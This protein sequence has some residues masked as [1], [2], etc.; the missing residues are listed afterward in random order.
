VIDAWQWLVI[1]GSCPC[2]PHAVSGTAE[3]A[4]GL[5]ERVLKV[6]CSRAEARPGSALRLVPVVRKHFP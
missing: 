1:G 5:H 4:Q 6:A 3:P 2:H